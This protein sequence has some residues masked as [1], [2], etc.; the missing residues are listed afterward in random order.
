MLPLFSSKS[1]LCLGLSVFQARYANNASTSVACAATG[2]KCG[3]FG[4]WAMLQAAQ[5]PEP[6]PGLSLKLL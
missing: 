6:C 2:S 4:R 1:R 3:V 5:T